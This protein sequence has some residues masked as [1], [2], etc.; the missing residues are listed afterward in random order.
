MLDDGV[1]DRIMTVKPSPF[2]DTKT[3]VL[4]YPK[5]A[6]SVKACLQDPES[7]HMEYLPE[8]QAAQRT[9]GRATNPTAT[10]PAMMN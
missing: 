5:Q 6:P 8:P 1:R 4:V 7:T 3:G 10:V 2:K 9:R